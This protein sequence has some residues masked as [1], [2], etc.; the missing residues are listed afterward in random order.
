MPMLFVFCGGV[1]ALRVAMV[2]YVASLWCV[3][4]CYV[5]IYD[6][7]V[8][9]SPNGRCALACKRCRESIAPTVQP[10]YLNLCVWK[11]RVEGS[12]YLLKVNETRVRVMICE[13]SNKAA[14][15][16][17]EQPSRPGVHFPRH[18]PILRNAASRQHPPVSHLYVPTPLPQTTT[19]RML[20]CPVYKTTCVSRPSLSLALA[21][22]LLLLLHHP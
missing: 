6:A 4:L 3:S 22:L 10:L 20:W 7:V 15:N 5:C 9:G 8:R 19:V 16:T 1:A 21:V 14:L 13:T 12:C 17:Q 11:T 2:C 18:G